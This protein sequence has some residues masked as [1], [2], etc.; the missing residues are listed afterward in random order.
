MNELK[1]DSN[2]TISV[3]DVVVDKTLFW[4][5]LDKYGSQISLFLMVVGFV[6]GSFGYVFVA[7]SFIIVS[8]VLMFLSLVVHERRYNNRNV[9]I[10]FDKEK[11]EVTGIVK[12]Y[13]DISKWENI[14][15]NG[16][17]R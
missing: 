5:Y 8:M 2:D 14:K 6:I 11:E 9:F 15:S 1:V 3:R 13:G 10:E 12:V 16:E 4:Y 17:K 7:L